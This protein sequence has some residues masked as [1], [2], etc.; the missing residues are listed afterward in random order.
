MLDEIRSAIVAWKCE[1]PPPPGTT[2]FPIDPSRPTPRGPDISY[3]CLKCGD[4]IPSIEEANGPWHCRC[5]SIALDFSMHRASFRDAVT[6]R[7]IRASPPPRFLDLDD[8]RH[9]RNGKPVSAAVSVRTLLAERSTGEP[10]AFWLEYDDGTDLTVAIYPPLVCLQF[11]D[12]DAIAHVALPPRPPYGDGHFE[13]S[14]GGTATP[15]E[16]RLFMP[17]DEAEPIVVY[18]VE[19][20]RMCPAATWEAV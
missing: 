19:M 11:S 6:A 17:L 10:S 16:R 7:G 2:Y 5:Y 12:A 1:Q 15:L 3:E 13:I 18:F 14:V 4:V 20:G 8:D 9:P